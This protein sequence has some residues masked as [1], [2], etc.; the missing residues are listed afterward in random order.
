MQKLKSGQNA[1]K[2]GTYKV[3]D[4]DGKTLYTVNVEKGERMPPTQGKNNHFELQ[5]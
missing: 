5:S 1:P 3:V 4:S 2:S